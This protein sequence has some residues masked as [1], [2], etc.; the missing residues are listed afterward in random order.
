MMF[1]YSGNYVN[2][3]YNLFEFLFSS[4]VAGIFQENNIKEKKSFNSRGT[5]QKEPHLPL[6]LGMAVL[7]FEVLLK[8]LF[9]R[10]Q[11]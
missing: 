7:R 5:Q 10:L 3:A 8:N 2:V 1:V 4:N 11:T 9:K 6:F